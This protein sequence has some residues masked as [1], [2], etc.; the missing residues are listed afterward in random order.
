[1]MQTNTDPTAIKKQSRRI[2]AARIIGVA[3][4]VAPFLDGYISIQL[5]H[6]R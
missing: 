1:M 4:I 6:M 3:A 2:L 5:M